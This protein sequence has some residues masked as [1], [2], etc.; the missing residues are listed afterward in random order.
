[1]INGA[2]VGLGRWGRNLVDAADGHGR[3]KLTR[4]VETDIARAQSFCADHDLDLTADFDAVLADRAIDAVLLATPHSLHLPQVIACG[5]RP[6]AGV[7]RKALG[8]PPR[9]CSPDVRCLPHSRR[10]PRRRA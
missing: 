9:P 8:A 6:Q 2:I 3:L 7:L 4:A 5:S 10:D 1:M